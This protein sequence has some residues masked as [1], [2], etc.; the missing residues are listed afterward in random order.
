MQMFL[1]ESFLGASFHLSA[2]QI[3]IGVSL[4]WRS[5]HLNAS[6]PFQLWQFFPV[7]RGLPP[8][9]IVLATLQEWL[10]QAQHPKP[11]R[12]PSRARTPAFLV[13]TDS[14]P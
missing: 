14:H 2:G 8:E 1:F 13:V 5:R 12:E 6:T 9:V 11:S 3:D 10:C 7:D 4:I